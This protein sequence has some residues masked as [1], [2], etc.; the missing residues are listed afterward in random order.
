MD[1]LQLDRMGKR[2]FGYRYLGT[3]PL[4]KV[5]LH[6]I[7]NATLQHFVI[8]THTSNLHGQHWIAVTVHNNNKAYIFDSFG[9]PPPTLLVNQLQRRGITKIY[10]SKH[11]V[12]PFNT[13]ICGE[14]ALSHLLHV[15]ILGRA[16]G[17]SGWKTS[18]LH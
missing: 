10:Y 7:R 3:F 15:D 9:V 14:L 2:L 17:L 5:P 4:D 13:E 1:T 18:P 6:F 12:Q 16:R 8:N 11:Q